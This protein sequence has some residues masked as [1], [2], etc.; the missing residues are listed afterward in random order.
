MSYIQKCFKYI[1][2]YSMCKVFLLKFF[3]VGIVIVF[4]LVCGED[5][6]VFKIYVLVDDCKQDN[7]DVVG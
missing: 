7:L 4:L 2:L 5:W 3:V 1:V 6:D